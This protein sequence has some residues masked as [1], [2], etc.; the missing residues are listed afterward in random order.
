MQ[1]FF[2]H[3]FH[4]AKFKNRVKC[5]YDARMFTNKKETSSTK[6]KK[7]STTTTKRFDSVVEEDYFAQA[8]QGA[9]FEVS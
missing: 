6:I 5:V 9:F 1:I 7:T 4:Q 2:S 3:S 8:A